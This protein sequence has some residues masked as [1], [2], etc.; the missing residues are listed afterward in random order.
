MVIISP[1][2][3]GLWD[4]FQMAYRWLIDGGDPNHLLFG[5]ILQVGCGFKHFCIFTPHLGEM[6]QFDWRIFFQRGWF[7][8]PEKDVERI[9]N[10]M[11]LRTIQ[12]FIYNLKGLYN[13][14][15]T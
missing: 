12:N 8:Q 6:I 15:D 2:R 5:M 9:P 13:P 4:P 10:I 3:I 1:L 7:N 11:D 14:Q